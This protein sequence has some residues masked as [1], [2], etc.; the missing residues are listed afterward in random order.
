MICKLPANSRRKSDI[1]KG[2][3]NAESI[4]GLFYET[5]AYPIFHPE[6]NDLYEH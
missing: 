5:K 3:Q 2:G 4:L 6:S 1:N